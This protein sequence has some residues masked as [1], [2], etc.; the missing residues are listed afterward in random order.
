MLECN[1]GA[2]IEV[3]SPCHDGNMEL[4]LDFILFVL[5]ITDAAMSRTYTY[6]SMSGSAFLFRN[7]RHG[8]VSLLKLCRKDPKQVGV[9]NVK[10]WQVRDSLR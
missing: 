3:V 8:A 1:E 5:A 4:S 9:S 6:T 7:T 2:R 10:I